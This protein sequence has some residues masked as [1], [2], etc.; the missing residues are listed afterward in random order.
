MRDATVT[1]KY[2][3][4][5]LVAALLATAAAVA[6]G[7]E[8]PPAAP[9]FEP[10]ARDLWTRDA[11]KFQRRW[12]V[13]GPVSA[14]VAAIAKATA[15]PTPG[16]PVSAAEADV[17]WT[18]LTAWSDI[19]DAFDFEATMP[20]VAHEDGSVLAYAAIARTAAGEADLSFA[21]DGALELWLNGERV[22]AR[23]SPA[24]FVADGERIGVRLRAGGNHLYAR[25]QR[26]RSGSWRFALRVL[27]SGTLAAPYREI[28]PEI[29]SADGGRLV[30]RTHPAGSPAAAPVE[31]EAIAAGGKI[32]A[33]A[34][35]P[36]GESVAFPYAQWKDGAYELR[37]RTRDA[38][39]K[40][41]VAHLPWYK[42]SVEAAVT[43]LKQD[44]VAAP[45]DPR[46]ATL[47]MLAAMVEQRTQ[48]KRIAEV[49][50]QLHPALMEHEEL[51]L[52][53]PA[54][55]GGFRRLAYVDDVD[56]S[57]QF[58]RAYLPLGYAPS[59]RWPVVMHLHG[60]HPANPP[61]HAWWS[62]DQR[63]SVIADEHGAIYIEPHGRGNSQ[64]QGIGERDVLRCLDEARREFS[65]DDDRVYLTG[66]SMG[67]HGTWWIG[68]RNPGTFAAIAP[69]FGGWDFRVVP[70]QGPPSPLVP[71]TDA[72][73]AFVQEGASTFS[74]A[75]GLLNV[76]VLVTHGDSDA[77]VSV[78]GSRH[79]VRLLQRWNYDVR[80]HE[81][82]GGG[83]EDLGER[84]NIVDWLLAHRRDPT[85]RQVRVR[86]IDLRGA[87][88]H[89]LTVQA[90]EEP[91]RIIRA[92][93]EV[94]RPGVVRMDSDNVAAFSLA[95]PQELRGQGATVSVVWNGKA[96]EIGSA[97]GDIEV[98]GIGTA[99]RGLRKRPGVE[100]PLPDI[101]RTPFAVVVGTISDD[102]LMRTRCAQK[103]EAFAQ[104][105]RQWQHQPL[106]V[107]EDTAIGSA[108]L[109]EY[110]LILIG[111][112]DANA[113]TRSL[114]SQLPLE[115]GADAVTI[116][117]RRIPATDAVAQMIYPHP[118][119]EQRYVMVVAATSAAGMHFWKPALVHPSI[120]FGLSGG[121]WLVQ[122][123]R[124]LPIGESAALQQLLVA[125][126]TFDQQWKLQERFTVEGN[127]ALRERSH[128]RR[129]PETDTPM[130]AAKLQANVGE[131]EL[132]PGQVMTVASAED[133]LIARIPG[134][135]DIRLIAEGETSF[136]NA[137]TGDA[138]EFVRDGSGRVASAQLESLGVSFAARR[139]R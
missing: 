15:G 82:P 132:F 70:P 91:V 57:V 3:W 6:T 134:S 83:H 65:V 48:R 4:I 37:L 69:V 111:G 123:G 66:E 36:R 8:P 72:R 112:A 137:L 29:V 131:Y 39:G 124:R 38:W 74:S 22:F 20:G 60:Y 52:G 80:Y 21:A 138:I 76:P 54:S 18:P 14:D 45:D 58:C 55:A 113:V 87:R 62:A 101:L 34:S 109:A 12:L 5:G 7:S 9:D 117:G 61:Y 1:K 133:G 16:Q 107:F 63:H 19:L 108:E 94:V 88:A 49:W 96:H 139:V 127:R 32:V 10:A 75:E 100:G 17:R 90:A 40:T 93:A 120:G 31:V 136:S 46:G 59:Q 116:D 129:A 73:E 99:P 98:P 64:Y 84:G 24:R 44:A 47:R 121:D 104:L 95:L 25:L 67:G 110:S 106:R 118:L 126:G 51:R 79:I 68:S 114:A 97:A 35:V 125:H 2:G 27:E 78:E 85:P 11:Q 71:P 102:P 89:W 41:K 50:E 105:W 23:A 128:L 115:I 26:P 42:G 30:M 92:H 77:A 135:P 43:A 56:G 122:D 130:P 86:S 53:T 13:A 119:N 103:A 33:R 28:A 81:I